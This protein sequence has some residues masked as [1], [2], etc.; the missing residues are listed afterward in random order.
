MAFVAAMSSPDNTKVG[1]NG[2][3]VYTED[4]VGNQCVSLF[5]MLNRGLSESYINRNVNKI[6]ENLDV[7]GIGQLCDLFVMTF[8]TRDIRGGKGEKDLFYALIKALYVVKPDIVKNMI[9][10]IPE[11]GC[12]RDMWVLMRN[13]PELEQCIIEYT[14]SIFSADKAKSEGSQHTEMSLLAKWLPREGSATYPGI[15]RKIANYIYSDIP[16]ARQ[17]IVAYRKQVSSLNKILKTVEINMCG[18]DWSNIVPKAVPGHNLKI[19]KKAF[20]NEKLDSSTIRYPKSEDRNKCRTHFLEFTKELRDGTNK[21]H[22]AD[23]VMPHEL[24]EQ[25]LYKCKSEDEKIINQGQWN[26]IREKTLEGGRLGKCVPMC[27]FSGSMDGRPKLISLALGILIS[28]INHSAFRDHILTFDAEPTWHSFTGYNGIKEKVHSI[29]NH[30]GTGLNT[31]FYKACMKI[32]DKMKEHRVPIGE[33]PDDVIVLTDMGWDAASSSVS[34]SNTW[35]TQI[36]K[37]R[38]EFKKGSEEVWGT[39]ESGGWKVP[40]IVIWNLQSSFKDFH[41]KASDE[42]VVML[43][44][45]SPSMLKVLQTHGVQ[46]ITPYQGMRQILDDIRYDPVRAIFNNLTISG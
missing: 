16:S 37:I 27:D 2:E 5:T 41:A 33:E 23:V 32:L 3:N 12:W 39:S 17:R 13:I 15:A 9:K 4:G 30:L 26:S 18:N 29:S 22:G 25:I 20:L 38:E 1:V 7:N 10:L 43:S 21:A 28:E 14:S 31:N 44:G 6:V 8:Q 34:T 46:V 36:E 24:I 40:R 19:H 42:G 45:W 11:Y 35:K